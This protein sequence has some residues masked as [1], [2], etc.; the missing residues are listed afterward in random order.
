MDGPREPRSK[1]APLGAGT[2]S[3]LVHSGTRDGGVSESLGSTGISQMWLKLLTGEDVRPLAGR[4]SF[5]IDT[6]ALQSLRLSTG[7]FV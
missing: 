2:P 1:W 4:K 5:I 7:L 3:G 6:L